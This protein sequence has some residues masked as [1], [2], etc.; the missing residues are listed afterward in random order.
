[1]EQVC[2]SEEE[3]KKAGFILP[4]DGQ[5]LHDKT[6]H[7]S[8]FLAIELLSNFDFDHR[9]RKPEIFGPRTLET[10]RFWPSGGF[11]RWFQ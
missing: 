4:N 11:A 3:E 8:S 2:I 9:T 10:V 1:M 5:T 7:R 6:K